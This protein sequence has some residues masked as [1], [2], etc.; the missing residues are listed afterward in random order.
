MVNS[1]FMSSLLPGPFAYASKVFNRWGRDRRNGSNNELKRGSKTTT[2]TR[3]VPDVH[4]GVDA[5]V[6]RPSS[7]NV[8]PTQ[9][10]PERQR[11]SQ[12]IQQQQQQYQHQQ[13][14]Q[15]LQRLQQPRLA[16]QTSAPAFSRE[17][18][19]LDTLKR[20]SSGRGLTAEQQH[21]HQTLSSATQSL[22]QEAFRPESRVSKVSSSARERSGSA[23]RRQRQKMEIYCDYVFRYLMFI[24]DEKPSSHT[25]I[26]QYIFKVF[27]RVDVPCECLVVAMIYIEKMLRGTLVLSLENIRI[28]YMISLILASKFLEDQVWGNEDFAKFS[29][30]NLHTI[31]REEL[32]FL[33][34]LNFALFV[35][36]KDYVDIIQRTKWCL[37][38]SAI[39]PDTKRLRPPSS[40][41]KSRVSGS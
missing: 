7:A 5:P 15:Q 27:E 14:Q 36:E 21:H 8:E 19:Q 12:I 24:L 1:N 13:Q 10:R 32:N 25:D 26:Q 11:S 39:D 16:R 37:S 3:P 2:E 17:N 40:S 6:R 30:I 31:N 20:T 33:K 29:D 41:T 18:S 22:T 28:V 9:K 4:W 38:S 34:R 35:G 23:R